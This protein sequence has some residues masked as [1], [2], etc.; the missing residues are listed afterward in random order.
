MRFFSRKSGKFALSFCKRPPE[1]F[2]WNFF[3]K[4]KKAGAET[5]SGHL[6][7]FFPEKRF[8]RRRYM[9]AL[10]LSE[11]AAAGVAGA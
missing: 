9:P 8:P 11:Y 7:S 1:C 4:A 5:N 10:L 3:E 6:S 2:T